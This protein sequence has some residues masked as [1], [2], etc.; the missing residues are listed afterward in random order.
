MKSIRLKRKIDSEILH[1]P[2]LRRFFGK[3]IQIIFIEMPTIEEDMPNGNMN[4]FIA[5]AG[6]I[7]IDADAIE[8]LR[9]AS[10]L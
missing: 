7:D 6:N 4:D 3:Q 1:I 5:L 10:K 2:E 8:Q 9:E